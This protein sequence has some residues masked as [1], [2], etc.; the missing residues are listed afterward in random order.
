MTS[1]E[2]CRAVAA[3][4]VQ[5][6]FADIENGGDKADATVREV[7]QGGLDLW[8]A[9][10]SAEFSVETFLSAAGKARI[11]RLEKRISGRD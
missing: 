11:K 3:A 9:A 10:L 1:D 4:V 5:Q 7:K 8:L 6:A 2:A